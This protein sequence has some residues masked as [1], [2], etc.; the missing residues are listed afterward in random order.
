MLCE[1]GSIPT[2]SAKDQTKTFCSSQDTPSTLFDFLTSHSLN[3]L[4]R[5]TIQGSIFIVSFPSSK[6]QTSLFSLVLMPP[7]GLKLARSLLGVVLIETIRFFFPSLNSL[8]GFQMLR[9]AGLMMRSHLCL[10]LLFLRR[11][12]SYFCD[13]P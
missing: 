2:M 5:I 4:L 7:V 8:E 9:F 12:T 6:L 10:Y 3:H 11:F 13:R 1:S